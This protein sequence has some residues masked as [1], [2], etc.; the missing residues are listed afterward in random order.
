MKSQNEILHEHLESLL[1]RRGS[2]GAPSQTSSS[3]SVGDENFDLDPNASSS[4]VNLTEE[5]ALEKTQLEIYNVVK[6]LR[7]QNEILGC[8]FELSEQESGRLR[9]Q[10]QQ[11]SRLVEELKVKLA[12]EQVGCFHSFIYLFGMCCIFLFFVEFFLIHFFFC[13]LQEKVQMTSEAEARQEKIAEQ[14]N[15]LSLLKESNSL[16]RSENETFKKRV[17]ELQNNI[18]SSQDQVFLLF[19]LFLFSSLRY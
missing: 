19:L 9:L 10:S 2:S 5:N 6:Y 12:E 15:Q 8:R 4:I 11:F 1:A 14:L 3:S 13:L 18:K 16:L 17:E 7:R